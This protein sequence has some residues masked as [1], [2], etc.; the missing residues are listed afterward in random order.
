[1]GKR[2]RENTRINKERCASFTV[3][4]EKLKESIN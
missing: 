4:G 3:T 1:M 2:L